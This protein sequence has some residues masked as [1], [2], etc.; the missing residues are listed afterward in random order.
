MPILGSFGAGSAKGFG[1]T[2]KSAAPID[3]DYLVVAGGGIWW[4]SVALVMT[5]NSDR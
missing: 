2:G 4:R 5:T 3:V 1:L